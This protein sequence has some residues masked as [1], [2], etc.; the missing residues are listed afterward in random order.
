MAIQFESPYRLNFTNQAVRI[1]R[2]F[3]SRDIGLVNTIHGGAKLAVTAVRILP[4]PAQRTHRF[5]HIAVFVGEAGR[6]KRGRITL[7]W[8]DAIVEQIKQRGTGADVVLSGI[9]AES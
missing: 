2:F 3:F 8:G 5:Q 4:P 1:G 6:R 9:A 7:R